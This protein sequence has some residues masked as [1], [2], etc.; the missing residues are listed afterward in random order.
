MTEVVSDI[1]VPK[2][3]IVPY[4]I[5]PPSI[6]GSSIIGQLIMSGSKLAV[7]VNASGKFEAITSA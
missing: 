7:C 1:V 2:V 4:H 3:L 5:N 6:T